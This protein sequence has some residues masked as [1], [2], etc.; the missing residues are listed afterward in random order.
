VVELHS[1]TQAQALDQPLHVLCERV[2]VMRISGVCVVAIID[3]AVALLV[4]YAVEG[5]V[6]ED[7]F[8]LGEGA[9][10]VA[11]EVLDLS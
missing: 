3:E 9:G 10:F 1:V 2:E 5:E 6:L 4:G 11:E 7:H 8:V